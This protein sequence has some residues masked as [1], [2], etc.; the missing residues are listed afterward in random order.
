M[1]FPNLPYD[2]E[3]V[4]VKCARFFSHGKY[5]YNLRNSCN[6]FRGKYLLTSTS[7]KFTKESQNVEIGF[8][9]ILRHQKHEYNFENLPRYILNV[10]RSI[11]Q[12]LVFP[13]STFK[14]K[15]YDFITIFVFPMTKKPSTPYFKV[16]RQIGKFRRNNV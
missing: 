4:W 9:V 5:E 11:F 12:I 7:P 10:C 13:T 3:I 16:K 14:S 8:V 1:K 15:S 2:L 6:T